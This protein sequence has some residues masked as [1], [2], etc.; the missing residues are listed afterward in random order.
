MQL[1]GPFARRKWELCAKIAPSRG[2][3]VLDCRVALGKL[4][5]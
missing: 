5:D 4:K 1:F 3:T 2:Q